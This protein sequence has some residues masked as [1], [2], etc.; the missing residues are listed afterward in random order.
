MS[1]VYIEKHSDIDDEVRRNYEKD[2][3]IVKK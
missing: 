2:T 3:E 1:Y